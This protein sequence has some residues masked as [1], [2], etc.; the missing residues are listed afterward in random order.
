MTVAKSLPLCMKTLCIL[1]FMCQ[2]NVG[3]IYTMKKAIYAIVIE[4]MVDCHRYLN[5]KNFL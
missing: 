2:E 3:K 1:R 5:G 4:N